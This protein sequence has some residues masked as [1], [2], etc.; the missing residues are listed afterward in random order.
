MGSGIGARIPRKTLCLE[1]V[2]L[3]AYL[4]ARERILQRNGP[5]L[6]RGGRREGQRILLPR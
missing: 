4:L 6:R 3:A 1:V 2:G 5:P